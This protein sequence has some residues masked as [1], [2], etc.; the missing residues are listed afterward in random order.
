MK[1][2]GKLNE[3]KE[4]K[5]MPDE[6]LCMAVPLV[7]PGEQRSWFLAVGLADSSIRILS[8]D[9]SDCLSFRSTI[10]FPVT[11]ESLIIVRMGAGDSEDMT[12]AASSSLYLYVGLH[13]GALQRTLLDPVTGDLTDTRIRYLGN[14]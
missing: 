13:N 5:R 7:T 1:I 8:L 12:M 6:V 4:S 14:I 10:A 9:P 3:H 2:L 11:P